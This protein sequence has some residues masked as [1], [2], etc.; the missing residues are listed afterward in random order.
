MYEIRILP[1]AEKFIKKLKERILLQKLKQAIEKIKA[2]PYIG[3]PKKGDLSGIYGFDVF[4][5]NTN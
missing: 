1:R 3:K 4:Y 2:N 5:H